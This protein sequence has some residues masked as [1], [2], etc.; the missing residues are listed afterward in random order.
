MTLSPDRMLHKHGLRAK[1]SFGQ[2]F[3]GDVSTLQRIAECAVR[4]P[5][6]CIVELGAGLGHLTR[7]LLETGAR[8]YAI[9]RDRDLVRV[10]EEIRHPKLQVV[11]ADAARVDFGRVTL[12]PRVCVVG[13]I[14]YHLT[15]PILFNLLGQRAVLERVVLTVQEEV[16]VRLAARPGGRDFG[17]LPALLGLYFDLELVFTV[18]AELFFPKP[19]VNSAVVRL[20]PL[21]RP[22]AEVTS[23]ERFVQV[24]KAAFSRRRK[25][26]PNSLA[27]DPA[28]GPRAHLEAAIRH[29]GIDPARRAETLSPVEFA[30][31]ERAIFERPEAWALRGPAGP[32]RPPPGRT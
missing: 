25:T 21:P 31:L 16:A 7:I 4:D 19:K 22:R 24:V 27:S 28:L 9:E 14:P 10:L 20:R 3:L 17:L 2:N 11:A 13:N 12:A 6:E 30:L 26:L 1:K 29:A 32:E 23:H 8:V 18:D 15:S 5:N